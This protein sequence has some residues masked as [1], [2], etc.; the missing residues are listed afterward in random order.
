M[1]CEGSHPAPQLL[2]EVFPRS[3][4]KIPVGM[5][6]KT[7]PLLSSPSPDA[8]DLPFYLVACLFGGLERIRSSSSSGPQVYV[9]KSSFSFSLGISLPRCP[10][11]CSCLL[12]A[13]PGLLPLR[14][15]TSLAEVGHLWSKSCAQ[16]QGS[17]QE[18]LTACEGSTEQSQTRG[19]PQQ[20]V[21]GG[22][23]SAVLI[24][25]IKL[26]FIHHQISAGFFLLK[27]K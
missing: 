20:Q 25:S 13:P 17:L 5:L 19:V 1:A 6:W 21:L 3:S 15:F 24:F 8:T 4:G 26:C 11:S 10:A 14:W 9:P 18:M 2:W 7:I 16:S 23:I 27:L 12:Q 22:H